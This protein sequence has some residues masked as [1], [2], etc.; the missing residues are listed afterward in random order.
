MSWRRAFS[1]IYE[2]MR[3]LDSFALMNEIIAKNVIEKAVKKFFENP[4]STENPLRIYL[5][6]EVSKLSFMQRKET[7]KTLKLVT[8]F[9]S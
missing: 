8:E 9:F 3:W 6:Q 4:K 1:E 5:E 2:K 7:I